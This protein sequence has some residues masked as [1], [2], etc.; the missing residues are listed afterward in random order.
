MKFMVFVASHATSSMIR[1]DCIES[2][3]R[4]NMVYHNDYHPCPS[5]TLK[6][7]Y[8]CANKTLFSHPFVCIL[9]DHNH[10]VIANEIADIN[11]NN[12]KVMWNVSNYH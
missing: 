1:T 10:I 2:K 7:K 12:Y 8:L 6:E 5:I 11:Y 9:A 4:K 3:I